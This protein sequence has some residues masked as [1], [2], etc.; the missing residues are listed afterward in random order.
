MPRAGSSAWLAG[1]SLSSSAS[2]TPPNP[3]L[4]EPPRE[5]LLQQHIQHGGHR[6]DS[7]STSSSLHLLETS[8][9]PSQPVFA[10]SPAMSTTT[11]PPLLY[12]PAPDV[13]SS[14][15]VTPSIPKTA[16]AVAAPSRLS[17]SPSKETAIPATATAGID[18]V[19]PRQCCEDAKRLHGVEISEPCGMASGIPSVVI[20]RHRMGYS[21]VAL[22]SR[23][24][25]RYSWQQLES[26]ILYKEQKYN[27]VNVLWRFCVLMLVV[28]SFSIFC[29]IFSLCTTE[30]VSMQ[31]VTS[32]VSIGLFV[33]CNDRTLRLC[34]TRRSAYFPVTVTDAVTG[35]AV[36]STSPTFLRGFIG[37]MWSFGILQLLCELLILLVALRIACRPTRSGMLLVLFGL[38]F[39]SMVCGIINC[40]L[41]HFYTACFRRSCEG[42]EEAHRNCRVDFRYGYHLYIAATALHAFLL[43]MAL[44]MHSFIHSIRHKARL[45]LRAERR[46]QSGANR[47]Q[48]YWQMV[49]GTKDRSPSPPP[50][51]VAA[52]TAATPG[53]AATSLLS[54]MADAPNWEGG[55]G[56]DNTSATHL[57]NRPNPISPSDILVEMQGRDGD[58]RPGSGDG[59]RPPVLQLSSSA[60][61]QTPQRRRDCSSPP[62]QDGIADTAGVSQSENEMTKPASPLQLGGNT[63]THVSFVA[64]DVARDGGSGGTLSARGPRLSLDGSGGQREEFA[65]THDTGNHLLQDRE[66][67]VSG[68]SSRLARFSPT[69]LVGRK[70]REASP[71]T[72]AVDTKPTF[73]KESRRNRFFTKLFNREYDPNYLT[74]AELGVPIPGATDWV[75]DDRSDMY[76]SFDRNMFWDPLTREFYNCSLKSWHESPDQMV[77]VRDMLE[78]MLQSHAASEASSSSDVER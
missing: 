33:A 72:T 54:P 69:R 14:P 15:G 11:A 22:N 39:L 27:A 74:A 4:G 66:G 18:A 57:P 78:Y 12:F 1:P 7:S 44:C 53:P 50:A 51:V 2:T 49:L 13:S 46:R 76:Y 55:E 47:V 28:L 32:L 58:S 34:A 43:L 17:T 65:T 56:S 64:T 29:L 30:W 75:Y 20:L 23:Q 10:A 36:C 48:Q 45:Q 38:L 68:F 40:V 21:T 9:E 62:M 41:F 71:L 59:L 6:R 24:R 67:V 26:F 35:R 19:A 63:R 61:S 73:Q 37:A 77:E 60:V 25:C 42:V 5:S 52:P 31:D 70:S 16:A 3:P 8:T